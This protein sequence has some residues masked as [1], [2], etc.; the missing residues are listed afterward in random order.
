MISRTT[1]DSYASEA[2][3]PFHGTILPHE[4]SAQPT[5]VENMDTEA[6]DP[7]LGTTSLPATIQQI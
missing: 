6:A 2:P 4:P 1:T 5:D 3:G 7:S